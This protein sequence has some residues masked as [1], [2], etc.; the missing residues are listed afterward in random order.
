VQQDGCGGRGSCEAQAAWH[1]EECALAEGRSLALAPDLPG[2]YYSWG[3]A[4][5]RHG[6][7]AG[8]E[9]KLKDANHRGS[10]WADS[11]KSWGDLLL[12][13]GQVHEAL[14]KYNEALKFAPNWGALIKRPATRRLNKGLD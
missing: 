4:L 1:S 14:V 2:D 12:M 13:R 5:P 3:M 6:D 11:L 9:A 10:H 7:T 8:A